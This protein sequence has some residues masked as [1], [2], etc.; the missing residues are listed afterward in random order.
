MVDPLI[1]SLSPIVLSLY[2][3]SDNTNLTPTQQHQMFVAASQLHGVSVSLA[4]AQLVAAS[5]AYTNAEAGVQ[6]VNSALNSAIASISNV[7]ATV[8]N[9]SALASAIDSLVQLAA[10]LA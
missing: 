3:L 6:K 1:N 9:L 8:A 4:S 5:S 10:K 7:A 2:Q